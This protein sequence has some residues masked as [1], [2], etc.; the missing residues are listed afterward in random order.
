MHGATVSVTLL[1]SAIAGQAFA[2]DA[3]YALDTAVTFKCD[4]ATAAATL[5]SQ[6]CKVSSCASATVANS[7]MATASS[8]V[9]TTGATVSV[10][11]NSGFEGGGTWTCGTN[12]AF[13]GA[14]CTAEAEIAEFDVE[15]H[16][17]DGHCEEEEKSCA[18]PDGTPCPVGCC[19]GEGYSMCATWDSD[20][21]DPNED[22]YDG[23]GCRTEGAIARF[24]AVFGGIILLTVLIFFLKNNCAGSDDAEEK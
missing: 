22:W 10:A 14:Q 1:S 18:A 6:P 5:S 12:G 13:S 15:A 20:R 11:C 7:N 24:Y 23:T 17:A 2:C 8:L 16:C 9:G 4:T 3:G 21:G 19:S